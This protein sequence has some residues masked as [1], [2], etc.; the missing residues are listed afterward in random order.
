MPTMRYVRGPN[1]GPSRF[2]IATQHG[3]GKV[4]APFLQALVETLQ[5]AP[6]MG[7]SVDFVIE[8]GNCH[9]DDA[10]NASVRQ[11][12]ST[13]CDYL[14]FIDADVG[15]T[16][17]GIWQLMRHEGDVVCGVYPKKQEKEDYPVRF[18]PGGIFSVNGLIEVE[19]APTGFMRISRR[20]IEK[21]VDAHRHRQFIGS[22]GGDPYTIL[23]ERTFEDGHRWSGDYEFCRKWRRMGGKIHVD[24]EISFSHEGL[25]EWKGSLGRFLKEK[26][27]IVPEGFREAIASFPKTQAFVDLFNANG[28]SYGAPPTLL[29]AVYLLSGEGKRVIEAGS[30]LTTLVAA[31]SGAEVH[32][33]EHDIRYYRRTLA[34]LE[35]LGLDAHVHYAPLDP[36][37]GWYRV[38]ELPENFDL[39]ICD[40][41][42]REFGG[43]DH[44]WSLP[45]I[46]KAIWIADDMTG[47]DLAGRPA[48]CTEDTHPWLLA[49]P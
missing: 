2:L 33:L 3:D 4:H 7:W 18:A 47:S 42:P 11:F 12:L 24:P 30:G 41:P 27:G 40:G 44:F 25:Y 35:Q 15:W 10:R 29:A 49:R 19:G 1:N 31:A 21:M 46:E 26:A 32:S 20:C 5:S 34:W 13:D 45:G 8:C 39:A 28:E 36:E 23:F 37:T 48:V 6:S 17:K 14:L 9:V 43:R 38:P 16:P 22:D